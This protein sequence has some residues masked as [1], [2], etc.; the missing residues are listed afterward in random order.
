MAHTLYKGKT[1]PGASVTVNN[2]GGSVA[3][4]L[5]KTSSGTSLSNPVTADYLGDYKFYVANGVYDIA[6]GSTAGTLYRVR[7]MD[8]VET[9]PRAEDISVAPFMGITQTNVQTWIESQKLALSN[10]TGT[11]SEVLSDSPT[12]TAKITTPKIVGGSGT[13][14][15]L[16]YQTTTGVG[17]TGADHIFLVGNNG[18]TE[19]MRL[20]NSGVVNVPGTTAS[21]TY[22]NGCATFGGGIGVLGN[23]WAGGKINSASISDV[24]SAVGTSTSSKYAVF[25][26]G[27]GNIYIGTEGATPGPIV[28]GA[29]AYDSAISCKNG[30]S[31]ST[32]NGASLQARLDGLGGLTLNRI[33]LG[34]GTAAAGT[35]PI[36]LASGVLLATPEV[37]AIEFLADKFYATIT[38]AA[39]RKEIRLYDQ[40]IGEMYCYENT[41]AIVIPVANE[42]IAI[43]GSGIVTGTVAGFTFDAG[44]TGAIASVADYTGTVAGTI[45][46]TVSAGHNLTTGDYVTIYNTA[47][48]NGQYRIT[49]I[50]AT[51]YYVTK[52][53]VAT[54]TGNY[55]RGS[56]LV[57]GAT[58]AGVYKC[59]MSMTAVSASANKV[60]KIE[61]ALNATQLDKIVVSRAFATTDYI[62]MSS[63]GLVTI[64]AGDH[65]YALIRNETSGTNVTVRHLNIN[66]NRI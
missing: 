24:F 15:T 32:T 9:Q 12:F 4:T 25:S 34:A 8:Y 60:I 6:N 49:T 46:V 11:G 3:A 37:G 56:R 55:A 29:T 33:I 62:P 58:A 16:T 48:Y 44:V 21:T 50:S 35:A 14:Q 41:S 40:F 39:A 28:A 63:A 59:D 47:N 65:L 1:T 5:Y 43:Q 30:L 23:V 66:I 26:N 2:A 27:T 54:N 42:Y 17:A 57:A 45:A 22:T 20:L 64:A 36:K 18:A 19:A 52:A 10:A 51:E 31:I 7:I 61:M 13:T 38:T 53:Y